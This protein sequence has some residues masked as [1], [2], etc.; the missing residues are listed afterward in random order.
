MIQVRQGENQLLVD[1]VGSV[2]IRNNK[3]S[4]KSI[5]TALV[6]YQFPKTMTG[7]VPMYWPPRCA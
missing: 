2:R 5:C 4:T 6:V 3:R 1:G 7:Y